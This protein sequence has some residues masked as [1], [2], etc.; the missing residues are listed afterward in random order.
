[1]RS[2]LFRLTALSLALFAAAC[3]IGRTE[4]PPITGPSELATT[5]TLTASPDTLVQDGASQS[6]II[7]TAIGPNGRPLSNVSIRLNM[8]LDGVPQDYGTL[9]ARTVVTGADGRAA[10]I[11]TAPPAASPLLGGSTTM[12]SV[13]ATA[14]GVDATTS[15]ARGVPSVDIRLVPPGVILPPADTPTALFSFT[16]STPSANSPVAF[17]ASASCG[18]RADTSS[19]LPTNNTIV[20]YSW[21]FGD[22]SSGSGKTPTHTFTSP[23]PYNVTLTVTNDRGIAASTTRQVT[24]GAGTPPTAAFVFG[25]TPANVGQEVFFDASQSTA[26]LGHTIVLY[27]WNFGDGTLKERTTPLTQHDWTTPGTFVVRLTVVDEAG[28]EGTVTQTLTVGSGNPTAVFTIA[29]AGG[30]QIV[31]DGTSS[32]AAPGANLVS[33]AW[34]WGDGASSSG[35]VAAH[36]YAVAGTYTVTLTVTDSVGRTGR[37]T[38]NITVP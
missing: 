15:P 30:N 26:A 2:P 13:Q 32:T 35:T 23:G 11:Y 34:L 29:K 24:V 7:V 1:M 6:S 19:C 17:D 12:I 28:Q 4:A 5:L 36:T 33:W 25:P 16:P 3:T 22:G 37:A 27:K 31:A 9:S 14:V 10:A 18:G 20:S 8:A 38:Q 21:N